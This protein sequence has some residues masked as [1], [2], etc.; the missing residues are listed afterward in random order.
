MTTRFLLNLVLTAICAATAWAGFEEGDAAYKRG[1]GAPTL[2]EWRTLTEQGD[3]T[4]QHHLGWLYIIG[5]GVPQD[6]QEAI[7]WIQNMKI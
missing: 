4:A 6:F 7:R 5:R 2:K 3:L 1:D